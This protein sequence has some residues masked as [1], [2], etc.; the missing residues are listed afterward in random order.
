MRRVSADSKLELGSCMPGTRNH[1]LLAEDGPL[2]HQI[3][4]MG[5]RV[6]V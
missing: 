1:L 5:M 2:I 4:Y 3:D 6:I